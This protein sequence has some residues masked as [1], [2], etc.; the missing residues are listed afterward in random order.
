M[1]RLL[2]Y[3]A[4]DRPDRKLKDMIP[5]KIFDL[6]ALRNDAFHTAYVGNHTQVPKAEP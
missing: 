3:M 2:A 6:K 1:A 5:C 4:V